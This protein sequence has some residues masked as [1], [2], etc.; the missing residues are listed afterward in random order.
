[1]KRSTLTLLIIGL[2]L[3]AVAFV[4]D[5]ADEIP[6]VLSVLAPDYVLAQTGLQTLESKMLLTP[7]D[8]GFDVIAHIALEELASHYPDELIE[9]LSITEI[10]RSSAV[11]TFNRRRAGEV[12]P[13]KFQLSNGQAPTW[14]L[15]EV[16]QEVNLLKSTPLFR[17]AA[18]VFIA[19][20][21]IQL[22][23]IAIQFRRS[24]KEAVS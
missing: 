22:V 17:A 19:G 16:N 20:I 11:I 5:K 2:A 9:S 10:S 3:E 21:I 1:M 14:N 12:I 18:A 6:I 23:G 7:E 4:A 13:L 15:E 8:V 24:P